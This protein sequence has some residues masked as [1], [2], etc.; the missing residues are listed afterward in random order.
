LG[1]VLALDLKG[2]QT[3]L[4]TRIVTAARMRVDEKLTAF[5]ELEMNCPALQRVVHNH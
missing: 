2:E 3:G 5:L 4:L 1:W